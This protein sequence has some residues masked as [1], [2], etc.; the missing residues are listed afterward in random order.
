MKFFRGLIIHVCFLISV[1]AVCQIGPPSVTAGIDKIVYEKGKL[2]AELISEIIATKQEEVKKELMSRLV[3]SKLECGSFAGWNFAR[4]S[5]DVLLTERNPKVI[6]SELLKNVAEL[7]I[8]VGIAEFYLKDLVKRSQSQN[9]DESEK[10]FLLQYF[11]FVDA[12]AQASATDFI[13]KKLRDTF[14]IEFSD[15]SIFRELENPDNYY[16][17]LAWYARFGEGEGLIREDKTKELIKSLN[18]FIDINQHS[19]SKLKTYTF[20]DKLKQKLNS[21]ATSSAEDPIDFSGKYLPSIYYLRKFQ[22]RNSNF[23]EQRVSTYSTKL[24]CFCDGINPNQI[25]I[26]MVYDVAHNSKEVKDLGLFH[27]LTIDRKTYESLN[28]ALVLD[29]V[30][31]ANYSVVRPRIEALIKTI[32]KY[33]NT[34]RKEF[35]DGRTINLEQLKQKAGGNEV[36][37]LL[38]TASRK[39]EDLTGEIPLAPSFKTIGYYDD[40][41]RLLQKLNQI[42]SRE[43]GDDTD[44]DDLRYF[45]HAE[46]IPDVQKLN[47]IN[48]QFIDD[49]YKELKNFESQVEKRAYASLYEHMKDVK[50]I[51][52]YEEFIRLLDVLNNVD[53]VT[54]YDFLIKFLSNFNDIYSGKGAGVVL[55]TLLEGLDKYTTLDKDKNELQ[56][57]VES[58][59]VNMFDRFGENNSPRTSLYFSV[60]MNY[61]KAVHPDEIFDGVVIKT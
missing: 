26:D 40:L 16:K 44:F 10:K 34:L 33:Y 18:T 41:E 4:R 53:K 49:L 54:S 25:L 22:N 45:V 28:K 43:F 61:G 21:F 15:S 1:N 13:P 14:S 6:T 60:G 50:V 17:I 23:N 24:N 39:I 52:H 31:G 51:P 8:A 42:T 20:P 56:F 30:T 7:G 2:D 58:F 5:L 47:I 55:N 48:D 38:D 37:A 29:R 59:A 19:E 36:K 35:V 9:L 11:K 3:L 46:I 57:D 32:F 12:E 27:D